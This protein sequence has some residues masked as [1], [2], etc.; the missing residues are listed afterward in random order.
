MD[1][2]VDDVVFM[3]NKLIEAGRA[4]PALHFV[5]H[6]LPKKLPSE[7]LVRI[8]EQAI[9]QPWDKNEDDHNEPT[10]FQHYVAEILKALDEAGVSDDEMLH[11][12]WTYLPAL[13]YSPR[14]AKVLIKAL[15]ERPSFFIE[16]LS[17]LFK[18]S[19][20]SGLVEPPSDNPEHAQAIASRAFDLLRLWD[21]VPGTMPDGH[22]DGAALENWV[23]EAR[24][25][26][27]AVGRADIAD[28]KIGEALSASPVDAD[29]I[30]PASPVRDVIEITRSKHLETGFQ[31]GLHNRRGVTTRLPSDGGAQERDL[32]ARYRNFAKATAL[33]WPRTSASLE[34]IARSYEEDARSHDEDAERSEWHG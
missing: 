16:V 14:P 26:A 7:L 12:E 1:G 6:H 15:A 18:P 33:E 3:A 13:E 24:K 28:Q 23:K 32:V 20:E 22:I 21:R 11:L 27:A 19:E 17:A 34:R 30:W 9:R 25:L 31:I 29:G 2:D 5:G 8:L 4:R 10:M